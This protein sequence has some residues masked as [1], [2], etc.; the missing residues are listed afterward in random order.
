MDMGNQGNKRLIGTFT[1]TDEPISLAES[2][3]R[4]YG[5]HR[6]DHAAHSGLEE[7]RRETS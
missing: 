3:D 7:P 1:T 2:L 5:S 6:H 4:V